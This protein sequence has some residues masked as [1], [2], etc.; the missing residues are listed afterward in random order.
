MIVLHVFG[1]NFGLPDPSPFV[2]KAEILLKMAGLDYETTTRGFNKAPKGKLPYIDDNGQVIADSAFIRAHLENNYGADFDH[3]LS[4]ADRA[5]GYAF[6]KMCEEHLYWAVVYSRW[7]DDGNFN[8]GPRVFFDPVPSILRPLVIAKVRRDINRN[9][10]GHG[11]G[12]HTPEEIVTLAA[13]DLEALSTYL[14]NKPFFMGDKPTG[15]DATIF[16]FVAGCLCPHFDGAL[17]D[18]AEVYANLKSYSDRC[19]DLWF[20]ETA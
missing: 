9:M 17:R 18:E 6:A 14:G 8:K 15:A 12:R 11:L 2:T 1:P 10:H 20:A 16:P 7:A 3:G 19:R 4:E 13:K 5:V